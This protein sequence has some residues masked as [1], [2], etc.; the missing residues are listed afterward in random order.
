MSRLLRYK[1][2]FEKFIINRKCYSEVPENYIKIVKDKFSD[3]E[4]ILPILTLT[5]MASRKKKNNLSYQIYYTATA[6]EFL[7]IAYQNSIS[8]NINGLNKIFISLAMKNW[9]YNIIS[10][11][12]KI[13][14]EKRLKMQTLF[15]DN[16]SDFIQSMSKEYTFNY[17]D[18]NKTDLHRSILKKELDIN[19][20]ALKNI[21]TI[22][23]ECLDNYISNTICKIVE[24]AMLLGWFMGCGS[25]TYI[26]KIKKIS[27]NFGFMYKISNDFY[28]IRKDLSLIKNNK[29]TNYVINN[30]FQE[31]FEN[32]NDYKSMFIEQAMSLDIM[33]P[34]LGEIMTLLD[35]R[36]SEIIDNTSPDL[37]SCYS[38]I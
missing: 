20:N 34:T 7:R 15:L 11:N 10:I 18:I 1:Q 23:K 33:S 21:K 25:D 27:K 30:G 22:K 16:I 3:N 29:T 2:S 31:S 9:N 32:F 14:V 8:E 28:N 4:Y 5:I 6:T 35:N 24:I 17:Y 26:N 13:T 38:I 36:V 37:K 19:N 12:K